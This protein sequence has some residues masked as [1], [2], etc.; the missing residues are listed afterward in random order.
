MKVSSCVWTTNKHNGELTFVLQFVADR[1]VEQMTVRVV[2][3]FKVV[4]GLHNLLRAMAIMYYLL[5]VGLQ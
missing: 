1:W 3:G 2:P 4:D 5:S